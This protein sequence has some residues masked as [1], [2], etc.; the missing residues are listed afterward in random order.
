MKYLYLFTFIIISMT[1]AMAQNTINISV[2]GK[3]RIA[4]LEDNA[5]T[6]AL[7]NLLKKGPVKLTM[8]DYGGFE[9][10]G[11]LPEPLPTSNSQITTQPGDIMLY[12][13]HQLV[14]FYGTNSWSY[15][16]IG[17]INDAS[18][19]D[20]KEFLDNGTI[21][22]TLSL[23][24]TTGKEDITIIPHASETIYDLNGRVISKR[25]NDPG[26]YIINNRKV[27]ITK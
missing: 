18:A 23:P 24:T 4:T 16:R 20:V 26:I 11:S 17:K 6:E 22:V 10:V 14:I 9:K 21:E 3:T 8:S 19:T 15:T 12:Q 5:A 25:P 2:N 13:G 1:M 7:M 27:V